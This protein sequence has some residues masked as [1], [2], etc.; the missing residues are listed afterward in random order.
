M[1]I[2]IRISQDFHLY[3]DPNPDPKQSS[4][5]K[6]EQNWLKFAAVSFS[7]QRQRVGCFLITWVN[8]IKKNLNILL[9]ILQHAR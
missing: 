7:R 1:P 6:S 9:Q 3:A 2:Q 4:T 5:I 8:L